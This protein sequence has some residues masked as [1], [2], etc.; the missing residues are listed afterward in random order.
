[1]QLPSFSELGL[2]P[3][4][5]EAIELLG[6][7]QPSP[8]QAKSIP[9]ALAGKDILGLSQ[10]GSG[11]TAAFGL[12]ALQML[13]PNLAETQVIIFCPTR[14]LS[15]QVCE[16]IHRLGTRIRGLRAIPVYGGAPMDRQIKSLKSGAHVVVGTPG[17]LLDH[18]RRKTLRTDHVIFA[19]L[20]EADRML[21][22][23]FRED[24]ETLLDALPAERQTF[25][26]SATMNKNVER[27]IEGYANNPT[28]V[29]IERKTVT[30]DSVEQTYYEVS[31]RSKVEVLT[32]LLD[33]EPPRLGIVFCNTKQM[34]DECTE[35]LLKRGYAAD[36]I[37]GDITQAARERVLKRFRAGEVE[38]LVATDVA[39]RG[40]DVDDI[41]IVFN[42]DLPY[43]PEDYVHRIGRTGRAG[44]KGRAVSFVFGKD[45]YRLR[46]IERYI[47]QKITRMRIPS[48]ETL[49]GLHANRV[50]DTLRDRLESKQF[51]SQEV[52]IDRLLEQEYSPTDIASALFCMVFET[53]RRDSQKIA[54][55]SH[56]DAP[57]NENRPQRKPIERSERPYKPAPRKDF[58]PDK[59]KPAR[60]QEDRSE[61]ASYR[62]TSDT[63][64]SRPAYKKPNETQKTEFSSDRD[65]KFYE[66]KEFG[67]REGEVSFPA[68]KHVKKK[69]RADKDKGKPKRTLKHKPDSE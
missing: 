3:E 33:L 11:K 48:Q 8:I 63:S 10:T 53:G 37:H 21:D 1:M 55:D 44:R 19:V 5:L 36:S 6:Y 30:V 65:K 40:L 66:K 51:E 56:R 4:L 39:A 14:E 58:A 23:G 57:R 29:E 18:L 59:R 2:I 31:N 69:K 17:R 45:I 25:F 16:E 49:A 26:F 67:N 27:L 35:T 42:Y 60:F 50:F 9:V 62:K 12:P 54:E 32:R 47:R 24:M 61:P 68:K 43:D 28:L 22:M 20:D 7:E 64:E 41:D 13:D 52:Y 15:I 46:N 34:V 38:L